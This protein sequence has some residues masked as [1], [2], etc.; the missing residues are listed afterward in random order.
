MGFSAVAENSAA[1]TEFIDNTTADVFIPEIWSMSAM[2]AREANLIFANLVDRQFESE[3]KVGDKLNVPQVDNLAAQTKS[4]N[5]A[6]KYQTITETMSTITVN[7]HEY[8]A[9]AVED[10]TKIQTNRDM[11]KL[12]AGKMGYGLALAVDDALAGLVDN[13]T[14]Y[15]GSLGSEVTD[16]NVRRARQY[17][18]DANVPREKWA[19][20]I[21]PAAENDILDIEKYIRDDYTKIHGEGKRETGLQQAY[22]TSVYNI[23]VYVS[24]NVEG[25][26]A[27]GHDNAMIQKEAFALIMQQKPTTYNQFDIDYVCW[28]V[29]MVNIYGYAEMRDDHCVWMKGS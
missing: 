2:Y 29:A 20:A 5:T 17:L 15:T 27:A 8:T 21:S 18:R 19:I 24:T 10:I 3:L 14:N 11:I 25:T 6:I 1:A 13:V 26:N 9:I 7:V 4:T 28:K 16:A 23:P 22:V 12:Y